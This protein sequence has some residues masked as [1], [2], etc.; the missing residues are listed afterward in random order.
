VRIL[1]RFRIKKKQRALKLELTVSDLTCRAAELERE[2]TNLRRENTWLKEIVILKGRQ[3]FLESTQNSGGV[4]SPA[5]IGSKLFAEEG[6]GFQKP[7]DN[8]S[9][10]GCSGKKHEKRKGKGKP[11][12]KL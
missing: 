11:E 3:N 10:A 1:A 6:R 5:R 2:A 4:D 7:S 9:K 8:R 12:K